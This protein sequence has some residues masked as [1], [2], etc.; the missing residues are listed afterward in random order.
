MKLL[1]KTFFGTS[2]GLGLATLGLSAQTA[3]NLGRLPL[4]FEANQSQTDSGQIFRA[5][6]ASSDLTIAPTQTQFTLRQANGLTA[7]AHMG[8]LGANT[9]AQI[10]GAGELQGKANYLIGNVPAQWQ[11]G[12]PLFSRVSVDN[13]YSG[14]NVVY[15]GNHEQ[16]EYDFNLA[17]GANPDVINLRFDD[18]KKVSVNPKGELVISLNGGEVVQHSPVAYQTI[19]GI[20]QNIAAGYKM[21]DAHTAAFSLGNYNHNEPLVIDPILSF[22]TYF[23]GNNGEI[24]HAV[25]VDQ[26]GNIYLAGETLSSVFP[27]GITGGYQTNFQG[28]GITG[29]GFVAKLDNT[30]TNL[31]YCTYIGGSGDDIVY[32]LTVDNNRNAY[33]TGTTRSSDFPTKNPLFSYKTGLYSGYYGLAFVAEINPSGSDLVYSTF[34][35][36]Y[37]AD[38]GTSIAVDINH[39]TY[40]AGYTCYTNFPVTNAIQKNLACPNTIFYNRNAFVAEIAPNGTKLNYSSYLGGTNYDQATGIAVDAS[41]FIYVTGFTASTNFPTANG[42][43]ANYTQLN[44]T[45]TAPTAYDAFICKFQPHFSDWVYSTFLGGS[46]IDQA[47]GIT[48]D[49][50]GN[51]YVVGFTTSFNFP[52]TNGPTAIGSFVAANTAITNAFLTKITNSISGNAVIAFSTVFG[53]NSQDFASGV[54]LDPAGNIF[55][56]GSTTSTNFP[57]TTNDVFFGS[58]TSTNSG[59]SDVFV[60]AIT[61]NGSNLLYSTYL[62]GN[63]ND[64]GNSI[65]VDASGNAYVVGQTFSTNLPAINARQNSLNGTSDAFL[66]KIF[67]QSTPP[68]SAQL[69][70]NALQVS[71]PIIGQ[72]STNLLGLQASTNLLSTNWPFSALSPVVT[73]GAYVYTVPATNPAQFFRLH[74]K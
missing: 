20:R 25:A 52:V 5:R 14:I 13:V 69:S 2:L 41:G 64:F 53:G 1:S 29:D 23:G 33:I 3:M 60:T 70:H 67:P 55:V 42:A 35:S 45:N 48:C 12:L 49:N 58:L 47:S 46:G 56:T 22:A 73:N 17:P 24:A 50:L 65:A 37:V 15:Y 71:W 62:G 26:S 4:Y 11:T 68:V 63:N 54:A 40:V 8:L 32:S 74:L 28:G 31:L 10:T 72:S 43:L 36:G 18:A 6:G 30:G 38:A 21:L 16:L 27:N 19:H 57:V 44:G 9:T 61:S 7:S 59:A 51:A 66:A 39:N 34:L